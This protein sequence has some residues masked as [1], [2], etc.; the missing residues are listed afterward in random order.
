M[1]IRN[2]P[3]ET[4][5][6]EEVHRRK[7]RYDIIEKDYALSYVLFGISNQ[8]ELSKCLIFKGG[9]CLKKC[10]FGDYRFSE[11]LDFS[12]IGA[13]AGQLLENALK[14]A[15]LIA[16]RYLIEHYGPFDIQIKRK[17]ERKA[18]PRGQEAFDI[19]V[20]F[21][22][23]SNGLSCGIKIEITHDEPVLL[24]PVDMSIIHQYDEPFEITIACYPIEEIISEKLR[25]LLQTHEKI[26][27]GKFRSR[28]R[29]YYDL[30]CVLKKYGEHLDKK[31]LIDILQMKCNHRQV[32]YSS[33]DNFF[34]SILINEASRAWQNSLHLQIYELPDC[35]EVLAQTR[36]LVDRLL[37]V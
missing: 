35:E 28:P 17:I 6:K 21:P 32:S 29:D 30:W 18:H 12:T 16:K 10:Y 22:K 1:E 26:A 3:L 37:M 20:K 14:D 5:L 34:T 31:K 24:T 25:A 8:S 36:V 4:K 7:V 2:K 11:D 15:A 9:T 23:H 13:P 19:R 27:Q 33:V